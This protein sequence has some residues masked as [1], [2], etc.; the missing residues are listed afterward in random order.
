[1]ITTQIIIFFISIL[2][3]IIKIIIIITQI[4][5]FFIRTL[6]IIR[7][8]IIFITHIIILTHVGG[9]G[10]VQTQLGVGRSSTPTLGASMPNLDVGEHA[11]RPN[12]GVGLGVGA[13]RPNLGVGVALCPKLGVDACGRGRVHA[14]LGVARECVQAQ[15][16]VGR[17]RAHTFNYNKNNYNTNNTILILIFL[18]IKWYYF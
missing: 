6:W 7:E 1:M 18:I 15:F 9:R 3:V 12:L 11:S 5:L 13:S 8:K 14:Q 4:I 10:R 2:C 16:R 17:G